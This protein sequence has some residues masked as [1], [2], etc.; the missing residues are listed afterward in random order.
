MVQTGQGLV[1]EATTGSRPPPE[2]L[3]ADE[4]AA[5]SI[6]LFSRRW[7]PDVWVF[8]PLL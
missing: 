2:L 6:F 4:P 1:L 5:S 3:L 7:T 8:V